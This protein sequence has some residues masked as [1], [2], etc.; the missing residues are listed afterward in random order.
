MLLDSAQRTRIRTNSVDYGNGLA[1]RAEL[2]GFA[3]ARDNLMPLTAR[4]SNEELFG[5]GNLVSTRLLSSRKGVRYNQR[6]EIVSPQLT[7]RIG[8]PKSKDKSSFL[9]NPFKTSLYTNEPQVT[10]RNFISRGEEYQYSGGESPIVSTKVDGF[11]EGGGKVPAFHPEKFK[12][13]L[14]QPT[15]PITDRIPDNPLSSRL[16]VFHS[17]QTERKDID[18]LL[19]SIEEEI[20][21]DLQTAVAQEPAAEVKTN[22]AGANVE[23]S[24]TQCLICFD[25]PPDAVFMEC[26]HGGNTNC[27]ECPLK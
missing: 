5:E 11:G 23:K 19:K 4:S 6:G 17:F 20:K 22:P 15:E 1:L 3:T 9:G 26:G 18:G 16:G 25:K 24:V 14:N 10:E 8:S 12:L 2:N 7:D 13:A 21:Q 27:F